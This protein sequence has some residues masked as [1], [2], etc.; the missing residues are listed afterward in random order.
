MRWRA[1]PIPGFGVDRKEIVDGS[2][3]GERLFDDDVILM[4]H[5]STIYQ[6]NQRGEQWPML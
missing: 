6:G 5:F 1:R 3:D 2:F 4:M